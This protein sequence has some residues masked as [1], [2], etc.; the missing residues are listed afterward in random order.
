MLDF[1]ILTPLP[2]SED[3][4]KL[5]EKGVW[6]D[7]DLNKY[8]LYHRVSHHPVMSDEE[9]EE[10]YRQAWHTYYSR[11]H[12]ETILRR[13]A[14]LPGVKLRGRILTLFTSHLMYKIEQRHPAEGGI[15]RL[16]F[17]R[18]RRPG[19]PIEHPLIFYPSYAF[20]TV[21]KH[22]KYASA[23]LHACWLYWRI[24]RDPRKLEYTDLAITPTEESELDTLALFQ[25]TSGGKAEVERKRRADGL[26]MKVEAEVAHA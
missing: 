8:D 17:R 25:D 13:A 1:T 23:A 6:M 4:K 3:H 12:I 2:G 11:D 16:K 15:F 20:E 5:W 18:D 22:A 9:W 10:A 7:P 24:S 26:H 21:V 19:M 14:A